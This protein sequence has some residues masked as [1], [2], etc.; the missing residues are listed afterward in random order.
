MFTLARLARVE[1]EVGRQE[2]AGLIWGAIEG[3]ERRT[4]HG[5]WLQ[6]RDDLAAPVLALGG[7]D[8]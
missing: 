3:E 1:A 2:R 4:I 7:R 6:V 5:N 8:V